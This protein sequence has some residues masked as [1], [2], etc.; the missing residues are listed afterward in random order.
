MRCAARRLEKGP[1]TIFIWL[2]P[3][4]SVSTEATPVMRRR[5]IRVKNFGLDGWIRTNDFLYPKQEDYLTFPRPEK[6]GSVGAGSLVEMLPIVF[7]LTYRVV[8]LS[9]GIYQSLPARGTTLCRLYVCH[10]HPD[11]SDIYL[12]QPE[13]I[14]FL[15]VKLSLRNRWEVIC[16]EAGRTPMACWVLKTGV[17]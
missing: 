9:A 7:V 12:S 13:T 10:S 14:G 2:V 8:C 16:Y 5:A 17:S 15:T 11:E 4:A 3:S 6:L 1:T